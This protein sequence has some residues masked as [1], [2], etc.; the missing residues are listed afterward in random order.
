MSGGIRVF[1]S[2]EEAAGRFGPCALTIGNFDGVHAGHRRILRRVVAVAR[3]RGWKPSA[4][5]FDPHPTRIV[6]TERAPRLMTTPARRASLMGEE[7]IEQLL[8]LPFTPEFSRLTPEEFA[9]Q[10]LVEALD[11]RA[12]LVGDNF[13]FGHEHAGDT[14][15][16][17]ELGR[18]LGFSTEVIPA[19]RMRGRIV[20]SSEVRR[21]VEA[22]NVSLACRL[23]ETP[24]AIEGEV[25]PGRGIGSKQTVPTLNLVP[26]DGLVPA[27]GVYVTRTRDLDSP[28][29]W[30]SITNCGRRPT[31]GG[32]ELTVETYLLDPLEGPAPRAIRVQFLRRLREERKFPSAEALK[33]QI[34]R[35]VARARKYFRRTAPVLGRK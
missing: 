11:A 13:R 10:V 2:L 3:E 22:G 20:S 24:F 8:V 1:W 23:L 29:V 32:G 4:L 30:D 19:I 28:R 9:R 7:G 21:L 6:A 31:F 18:R 27:T 5:S 35:D 26:G 25:A 12:V 16:L 15:T 14:R 33:E 17:A 34:M